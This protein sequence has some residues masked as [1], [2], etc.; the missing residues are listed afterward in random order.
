LSKR[1]R[2]Q[3]RADP[4]KIKGIVL[5][6]PG[7]EIRLAKIDPAETAGYS[8]SGSAERISCLREKLA[9]LQEALYAEHQR[10][11]LIVVQG[12][13]TGGKDGAIKSLCLGLD[14]NGVQ[15][16]NFKYP[17]AEER[18]H[19]FLWRVH[20]AA[21]RKGVVALWN[22]SHY[23]D[24]LVPLVHGE[25][26]KEAWRAR[27]A[28]INAFEKLLSGNGVTI[29]K[30]FLHISREEQKCRLEAR[31]KEAHKLWKF[32]LADLKERR[33][34]DDYQ[35]AYDD[36]INSCTTAPAPWWIVP[37]DR[38]WMRNLVMLETVVAALE[39]MDPKYP[40][41][42]FDPKDIAVE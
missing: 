40:A 41:A 34:W 36:V 39:Q 26:T 3:K 35:M 30:F 27:C 18:D 32:N 8:K 12:M 10:S 38:K 11:V 21:P 7:R 14:P 4:R 1:A 9:E 33:L 25:I 13:D 22:R 29:L 37:A 17:T 16:T 28:D 5:V 24:V 6:E 31:L 23:E 15:L 2:E 19:D 42:E 20:K